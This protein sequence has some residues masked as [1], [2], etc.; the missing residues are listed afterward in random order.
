MIVDDDPDFK[1][2]HFCDRYSCT[3]RVIENRTIGVD[4]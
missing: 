4:L 3:V 1:T 2:G